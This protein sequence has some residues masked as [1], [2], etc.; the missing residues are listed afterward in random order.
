[1]QTNFPRVR[2]WA[3]CAAWVAVLAVATGGCASAVTYNPGHVP[4]AAMA[5]IEQACAMVAGLPNGSVYDLNVCEES[6]SRSLAARLKSDALLATRQACLA[7]GLAPGSAA[8]SDCE[9]D[10]R[11]EVAAAAAPQM[12]ATDLTPRPHASRREREERACA[13]IGFEPTGAGFGQCVADLHAELFAADR[14][15]M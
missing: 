9:L 7:R 8:L 15:I 3:G 2:L 6:L 1:M 14:P 13:A 5:R 4:P 12:A 10:S 11:G